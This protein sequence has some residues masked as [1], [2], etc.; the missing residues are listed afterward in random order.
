[1]KLMKIIISCICFPVICLYLYLSDFKQ[2]LG[3]C[4]HSI[5]H[6]TYF[7]LVDQTT[8]PPS[9]VLLTDYTLHTLTEAVHF[10]P[11][12]PIQ[13]TPRP[14]PPLP[15]KFVELALLFL[16]PS[17]V[18]WTSFRKEYNIKPWICQNYHKLTNNCNYHH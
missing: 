18:Q 11:H 14:L 16:N 4:I 12:F 7:L 1:M 3:T 2:W 17:K 9:L 6:F 15:H 10:H 8:D 13:T 5:N